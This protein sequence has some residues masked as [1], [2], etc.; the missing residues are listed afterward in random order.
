MVNGESRNWI[1]FL[2]TLSIFHHLYGKWPTEVR[3]YSFFIDELKEKLSEHDFEKLCEKVE[4]IPDDENHFVAADDQG[5]TFDY[6]RAKSIPERPDGPD[7]LEW[8]GV[9]NHD[10]Y[11]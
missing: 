7:P 9:P 6:A 8:L 3:L 4:I 11:D 1:R 10:Y 2:T 5:N